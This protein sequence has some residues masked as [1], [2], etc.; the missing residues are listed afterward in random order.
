M[1]DLNA[2]NIADEDP[3]IGS[4]EPPIADPLPPIDPTPPIVEPPSVKEPDGI[5]GDPSD[6]R[7]GKPQESP[8]SCA[9]VA[10]GGVIHAMKGIA[11]PEHQLE[12]EAE[13]H[14]LY[15]G[16]TLP[17]NFGKLL[18]VYEIPYHVN[19]SGTM[20]DIVKELAYGRKVLV[21]V[22]GT[23]LWGQARG[24]WLGDVLDWCQEQ[25]G[26]GNHAV[27]VTA[28]DVSDPTDIKV[29]L[30][31]SGPSDGSGVG[32][33]YSLDEFIDAAEDT[34]FYYVATNDAAP[35]TFSGSAPDADLAN[36][37]KI[38]DYYEIRY[39]EALVLD[40]MEG[41]LGD[42]EGALTEPEYGPEQGSGL[43]LALTWP[44]D[45]TQSESNP[46]RV[47]V[48]P[49]DIGFLVRQ[50]Y[51][52]EKWFRDIGLLDE[53]EVM[54]R[55][56]AT[57]NGLSLE[58]VQNL[59]DTHGLDLVKRHYALEQI[60]PEFVES[61]ELPDVGSL[62]LKMSHVLHGVEAVGLDYL[63]DKKFLGG[64]AGGYS[65]AKIQTHLSDLGVEIQVESGG[66]LDAL[67]RYSQQFPN[68]QTVGIVDTEELEIADRPLNHFWK[69][70][71]ELMDPIPNDMKILVAI[72]VALYTL[73]SMV[74]E[75][76]DIQGNT[77][78][79]FVLAEIGQDNFVKVTWPD[80]DVD[81]YS[82]KAFERAFEDSNCS[83]IPIRAS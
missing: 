77:A 60:T 30:N 79:G 27:W 69:K 2:L 64:L 46:F 13:A 14:G 45:I 38:K 54:M 19:E 61:L 62:E 66:S 50:I 31:D 67:V 83:F 55:H 42:M 63:Y 26:I 16:G 39:N 34:R 25:L 10:A 40:D 81:Q 9:V 23:E 41:A 70:F 71:T 72:P 20:Q 15:S 28:I 37:P 5:I 43:Y 78:N 76:I 47:E 75:V 22:D 3:G 7:F 8:T 29:I 56:Y 58:V 52:P 53:P 36:F 6:T 44:D 11:I 74:G 12:A 1:N 4:T 80:G 17:E 18:G 65:I 24:G 35:G 33:V 49:K 68:T 59:V 48:P 57:A 21:G 32:S 73:G 82:Y 51:S